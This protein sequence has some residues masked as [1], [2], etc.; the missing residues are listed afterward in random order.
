MAPGLKLT[1]AEALWI[2]QDLEAMRKKKEKEKEKENEEE[3]FHSAPSS[4]NGTPV[5]KG[6]HKEEDAP[7]TTTK[8]S[9]AAA[10]AAEGLYGKAKRKVP[11]KIIPASSSGAVAVAVAATAAST[12]PLNE[13]EL[14]REV[15]F[16]LL[17]IEAFYLTFLKRLFHT[18]GVLVSPRK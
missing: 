17:W 8:K 15:C 14:A 13:Y 4:L 2:K 7:V 11:R 3:N 10:A 6:L 12:A 16:V 9:V 5:K 1:K 18:F